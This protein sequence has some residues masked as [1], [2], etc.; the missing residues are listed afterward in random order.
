MLGCTFRQHALAFGQRQVSRSRLGR[1]RSVVRSRP[2]RT[3]VISHL[4]R[5]AHRGRAAPCRACTFSGERNRS[6]RLAGDISVVLP[7]AASDRLDGDHEEE[8]ADDGAR[9]HPF[10]ADLPG[11][12]QEAR[13][14]RIP[15]PQHR[16]W[17]Q[18]WSSNVGSGSLLQAGL[19]LSIPPL[20]WS[21]PLM[22]MVRIVCCGMVRVIVLGN[23]V[24]LSP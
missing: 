3:L 6:E 5:P 13:V 12:G 19:E 18:G 1:T 14:D 20:P 2:D 9:E 11:R 4:W 23:V 17:H 7:R 15:V 24:V 22:S 8:H 16:D 10:G 21:I